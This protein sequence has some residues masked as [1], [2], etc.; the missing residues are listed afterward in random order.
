MQ[1]T[2]NN[3]QNIEIILEYRGNN[4]EFMGIP[5]EKLQA[6]DDTI[7]IEAART[8]NVTVDNEK[9]IPA[10]KVKALIIH[11]MLLTKNNG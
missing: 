2:I 10:K 3:L 7:D 4:E 11:Y 1:E 8:G 9:Y 5:K 6:I